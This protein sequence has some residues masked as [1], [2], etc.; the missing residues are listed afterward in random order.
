MIKRAGGGDE[1]RRLSSGA[2]GR[3]SGSS[4]ERITTGPSRS[5]TGVAVFTPEH[6]TKWDL[7]LLVVDD[8]TGVS[9]EELIAEA[10]RLQA[11]AGLRHRKIEVP[12]R[13]R[14]A[15]GRLRPPRAGPR[16]R[17]S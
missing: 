9:A 12:E 17:S 2:C 3:T 5:R 7:N 1:G 14:R 15:R 8:A 16:R 6:P 13:R 4:F 11:P 10:E